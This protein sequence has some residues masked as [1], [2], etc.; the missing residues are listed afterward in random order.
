MPQ[1]LVVDEN[2]ILAVGQAL[3]YALLAAKAMQETIK[4][5]DIPLNGW[6]DRQLAMEHARQVET[7]VLALLK[8]HE[9]IGAKLKALGY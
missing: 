2:P 9:I 8:N 7:D 4:L 5:M 3:S 1:N 6:K